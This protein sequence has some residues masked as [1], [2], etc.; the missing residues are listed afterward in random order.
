[1]DSAP[2]FGTTLPTGKYIVPALAQGLGVLSLFT[3]DRVML[4]T[5][6]IG[7]AL[8]LSRTGTFRIL[9]TLVAM[10][11]VEKVDERRFRL[12]PALL[13]R[14]FAYLASLDLVEVARPPLELLRD[15][16]GH[17]TQLAV[18]DGTEILYLARYAARSPLTSNIEV[19]T[20]LPAYATA[21]GRVLL[22]ERPRAEIA[23]L[24]ENATL[25]SFSAITPTNLTALFDRLSADRAR[26]HVLSH[27]DFEPGVDSLAL[28]VRDSTGMIVAAISVVGHDW[29]R[30]DSAALAGM[31]ARARQTSD[32][33]SQWLGWQDANALP[34]TST[35]NAA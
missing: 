25:K 16:T 15:E 21:M 10:G 27:S 3:R 7:T 1:M 6:E 24:Y 32:R 12:G 26:G 8:G 9:H 31:I 28:P 2:D 35:E 5:S 23:A 22:M 11:Y 30:Q 4:T 13:T 34:H 33:I 19:G 18:L 17:A 20:R 14:G 29:A